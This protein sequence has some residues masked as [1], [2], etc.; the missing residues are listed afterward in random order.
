MK[1]LPRVKRQVPLDDGIIIV[2]MTQAQAEALGIVYCINDGCGHHP[3]LHHGVS[4]SI[5]DG[6]LTAC[7]SC[8]CKGYVQGV[9]IGLCPLIRAQ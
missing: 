1:R 5:S 4:S 3:S 9:F 6:G 7:M 2:Q 8:A